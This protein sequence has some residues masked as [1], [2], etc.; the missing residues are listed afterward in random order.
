MRFY[1]YLHLGIFVSAFVNLGE[2]YLLK[3]L[4]YNTHISRNLKNDFLSID[5]SVYIVPCN[6]FR[7]HSMIV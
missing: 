4:N 3:K 5:K 6:I 7:P 2:R 1:L